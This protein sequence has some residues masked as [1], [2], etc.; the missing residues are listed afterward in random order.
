MKLRLKEAQWLVNNKARWEPI[1]LHQWRIKVWSA[2]GTPR[3]LNAFYNTK[4]I[5]KKKFKQHLDTK[6]T[7]D[8]THKNVDPVKEADVWMD[9]TLHK[10]WFE[11]LNDHPNVTPSDK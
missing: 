6:I 2:L 9:K 10:A 8:K 11:W 5:K 7:K 1:K 4:F 3:F